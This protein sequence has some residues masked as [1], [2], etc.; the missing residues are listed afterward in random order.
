MKRNSV[1]E[2]FEKLLEY[3]Q[4][5]FISLLEKKNMSLNYFS[6][7]EFYEYFNYFDINTDNE[8][9]KEINEN[10][11]NKKAER[12]T[13]LVFGWTISLCIWGFIVY[14]LLLFGFAFSNE[15]IGSWLFS[16]F[17]VILCDIFGTP[18]INI[19]ILWLVLKL[20]K[21]KSLLEKVDI[22]RKYFEIYVT[23]M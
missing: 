23:S 5:M 10:I 3:K 17:L 21:N 8:K 15:N 20:C 11:S 1:Y 13:K 16:F 4:E 9:L 19:C 22:L 18:L 7:E 2:K 6:S 14:Y 12:I